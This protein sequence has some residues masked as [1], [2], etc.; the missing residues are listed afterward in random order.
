MVWGIR[1]GISKV[2]KGHW[3]KAKVPRCLTSIGRHSRESW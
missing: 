1:V 2:D 3:L